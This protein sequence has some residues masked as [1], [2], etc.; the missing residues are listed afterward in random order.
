MLIVLSWCAKGG[1]LDSEA[2]GKEAKKYNELYKKGRRYLEKELYNG[3]YFY[4]KVD[5][6]KL[7]A[8]LDIEK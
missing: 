3:E 2:L 1:I 6:T 5:W 8:K 4:Q 7:E